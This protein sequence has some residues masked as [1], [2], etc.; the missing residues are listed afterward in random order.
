MHRYYVHILDGVLHHQPFAAAYQIRRPIPPYATHYL[1][2]LGL[3]H[4]F[5]ADWAEKV[6]VCLIFLGF[7][8]GLRATAIAVGPAGRWTSLFFAPLLLSWAL[9]MG[10]FN[11]VLGVSLV[12]L[13]T[14]CWQRSRNGQPWSFAW[15][16]LILMVL[17]FTHPVSLLLLVSITG[18]D[19]LLSWLFRARAVTSAGWVGREKLRIFM[20][21]CSLATAVVPAL[22][23][24]K[25]AGTTATTLSQ[26][27]FKV[28]LLRTL[29]LLTGMSPYNSR[30]TDVF[31]NS[32]RFCLYALLVGALWIGGKA[33]LAALR[34][35]R[36]NL[37]STLF[38]GTLL[39]AIALPILPDDVNGSYFF[40][41]R[42]LFVLWPSALIAAGLAP[43]PS[44]K[45]QRLLLSAAL[46]SVILTLLP[47]Q[48]RFRPVALQLRQA[49]TTPVPRNVS[50]LLLLGEQVPE[51][52][53]YGKQLTFD[54]YQWAGVLPLVAADDVLLD[55]PWLEQKIAPLAPVTGYHLLIV[56]IVGHHKA[57]QTP[58][59]ME[60]A[61]P[62][63]REKEMAQSSS[64]VV[65]VGT[66]AELGYGLRSQLPEE[67][68]TFTC[69]RRGT[70]YLVCV[71]SAT[72]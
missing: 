6:L 58:P 72:P 41:T 71:H 15:Y 23:V 31:I 69:D 50:G 34:E 42:L 39:L 1:L 10:F 68:S 60:H 44:A 36:P 33:A 28:P 7:A 2:L 66:P 35:R 47:A 40:S 8:V 27:H 29:L 67:A 38:V 17:A 43:A 48:L 30:S 25:S 49:E 57:E 37:G 24:D 46:L 51:Y 21:V 4:I 54:P 14:A 22:A 5:P 62:R 12:L 55:S 13:A 63:D 11:Y 53:R 64:Y 3:F 56:D 59:D 52:A 9:M 20:L 61:L 65:Y 32:Y 18:L 16:L 19:L 70:W 45:H 26:L